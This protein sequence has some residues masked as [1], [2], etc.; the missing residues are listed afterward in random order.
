MNLGV[1]CGQR[2]S[3]LELGGKVRLDR[4]GGKGTM[5]K[6]GISPDNKSMSNSRR[7]SRAGKK[8]KRIPHLRRAKE[9]LTQEGLRIP[10][11]RCQKKAHPWLGTSPHK[12]PPLFD[13]HFKFISQ[14]RSSSKLP[15]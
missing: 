9:S 2:A 15:D 8:G 6:I 5:E 13:R 10:H 1:L 4:M 3:K 7:E 12:Y 11:P 14:V